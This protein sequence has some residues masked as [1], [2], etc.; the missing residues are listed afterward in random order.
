V[1]EISR[2][3]HDT[4]HFLMMLRTDK[5]AACVCCVFYARFNER[6]Y[7]NG[8]PRRRS[9]PWEQ[10]RERERARL[11]NVS[12]RAATIFT[13]SGVGISHHTHTH[14]TSALEIGDMCRN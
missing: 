2:G 6:F 13:Q 5:R 4:E 3:E 14:T 7:K 11:I 9:A 1:R 12:S 10:S 8:V